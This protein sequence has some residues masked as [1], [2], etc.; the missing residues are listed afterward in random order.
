MT[1]GRTRSPL[2]I[3]LRG[4]TDDGSRHK[5]SFAWKRYGK[6]QAWELACLARANELND[7]EK[8]IALHQKSLPAKKT[9][10]KKSK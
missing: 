1:V 9:T 5:L 6:K 2:A 10:K 8:V 4:V 7:R 3:A